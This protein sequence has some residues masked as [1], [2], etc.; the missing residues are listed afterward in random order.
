MALFQKGK[1]VL[2]IQAVKKEVYDVSGAGDTVVSLISLGMAS[3]LDLTMEHLDHP[4]K[5][6][7]LSLIAF[8]LRRMLG[9][10]ASKRASASAVGLPVN[11]FDAM[12]V[13]LRR[14]T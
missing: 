10:P 7:P 4:W 6:V 3:G 9:Q 2:R 8:Q 5:I 14:P 13:V 11:L 12:R 1:S